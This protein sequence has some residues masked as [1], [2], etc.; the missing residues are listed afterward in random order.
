MDMINYPNGR[1]YASSQT[2]LKQAKKSK[3]NAVK[4]EIDGIVFDSKKEAQR[5]KELKL[6]E[7]VG[8][9]TNLRLQVPYVLI[10]K[11]KYG[12]PIR[13][14]ADFVYE[15]NGNEIVEDTKGYRTDVYKIKRRLMAEKY[16]IKIKET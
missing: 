13:Y 8:E 6:L 12:M 10:A 7:Q 5:Y 1:K 4:T 16:G 15:E 14:I 2:P 9:I 11:S 3:Y